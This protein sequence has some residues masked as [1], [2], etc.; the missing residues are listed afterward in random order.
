MTRS[1]GKFCFQHRWKVVIASL[2]LMVAGFAA[3]GS[4]VGGM[5]AV[6]QQNVPESLQ[7][8][9]L[10]GE[11]GSQVVLLV[12]G[13]DP[14]A[15]ATRAALARTAEA[16]RGLEGVTGVD[17]P[18][19]ASDGSGVMLAAGISKT[20][21]E[22]TALRVADALRSAG[23]GLPGARVR[24]GGD[25]W[26]RYQTKMAAQTD[27]RDAEFKALPLTFVAL[28]IVFGGVVAAGLP[29]ITTIVSVGAAFAVLLAISQVIPLDGNVTTVVTLLGLGLC[30]DYG[31]LLVG[32]YRE[33]LVRPYRRAAAAGGTRI[34]LE[35]RAKA[36]ERTWATAGR[37][38]MF[39]ALTVAAALTGLM[40]FNAVG[41]R[42]V[43]AGGAAVSLVA[44]LTA[45]TMVAALMRLFGGRIHPS[46]RAL[47]GEDRVGGFFERLIS[48]VQR[49]PV[50]VAV[51]IVVV[52]VALGAPMLSAKLALSGTKILPP[53]LESVQVT[54]VLAAKY[55]R[56]DR[57]AVL[58]L[59]RTEPER[60]QQ[61]AERWKG[62]PAVVRVE[63]ARPDG[64]GLSSVALAVRGDTQGPPAREL[65]ERVRA[66][67]PGDFRIWVAGQAAELVDVNALLRDGMPVALSVTAAAM[68]V[69]LFLLS[70]SI[71]VP[72]T[73]VAMA[74]V[75]LGA[76][77]GVLVLVFQDGWL[78]GALDT[79]TVGGLDPFALAVIFAF[80][81]GL[82]IDYEVFLLGRIRE[83]V[84]EGLGTRAAVRAGVRDTGRIITS[85]ALLM[86]VVFGTFGM[87][88]MG[89]IEQIGIG[90]FVAVLVDA[91]LVRCLLVPSVMTLM[92]RANWWAPAPL[93]RL[94]ARFG[95][96]EAE[97]APRPLIEV[98]QSARTGD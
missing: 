59:A 95:L 12:E 29:L 83:H 77:F 78:S 71:L 21:E 14:Q 32:R 97:P 7:A 22:A 38:V 15:E 91:T 26:L 42:A 61:W 11:G 47:R 74:V 62:D 65:V 67:R 20:G 82:S 19:T 37:T 72:L 53:D 44:M 43:A 3:A 13:V 66:D 6:Q 46:R 54:N 94:H 93:R 39:S 36:V 50:L 55:G 48:R 81:F 63:T 16:V 25:A 98:G 27:M 40:A 18:R 17:E 51:G 86:L 34:S 58:V 96:R 73:A 89:D 1:I 87:A 60:L 84:D 52:L 56:T 33:E 24:I 64:P 45:L 28:V 79:L 70:G 9:Q 41:L 35:E 69:L 57:P 30:I 5:S 92:G 68:L 49:F 2:L 80:A 4:V 85:A 90:L 23:D 8:R 76:T 75:S 88:R 31:L 10:L